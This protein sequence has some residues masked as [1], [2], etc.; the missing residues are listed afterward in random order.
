MEL[1]LGIGKDHVRDRTRYIQTQSTHML[2]DSNPD[3]GPTQD[4]ILGLLPRPNGVRGL[5]LDLVNVES[6]E[7][8]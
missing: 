3:L 1:L 4:P 2:A 7:R 8:A 5:G 6:R